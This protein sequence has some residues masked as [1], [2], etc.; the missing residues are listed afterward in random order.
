MS[1]INVTEILRS[2]LEGLRQ[3]VADNI[4]A[5]GR[6]ATGKTVAGL[7]V[8]ANG[9]SGALTGREAFATLEIGSRP[10]AHQYPRPP[11]WFAKLIQEWI[12]AKS[13]RLNAYAV[14][15]TLMRDGSRL[16]RQGGKDDVYTPEIPR[17]LEAITRRV[18][19]QMQ[20][21]VTDRLNRTIPKVTEI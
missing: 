2:E 21:L 1:G 12:D 6:N 8:E 15:T 10:W 14:A 4:V 17:T 20:V 13:L 19:S 9:L 5:T 7:S 3:R 18:T 16:R 11:K